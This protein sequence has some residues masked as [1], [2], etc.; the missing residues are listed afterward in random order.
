MRLHSC[1]QVSVQVLALQRAVVI[2]ITGACQAG[3]QGQVVIAMI[4]KSGAPA[5]R[6]RTWQFICLARAMKSL[7]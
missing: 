3:E 1:L 2:Y 7:R 4:T 6:E 5:C